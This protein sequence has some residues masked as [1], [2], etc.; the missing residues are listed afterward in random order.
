M[1]RGIDLFHLGLISLPLFNRFLLCGHYR[2]KT[3][4]LWYFKDLQVFLGP[5]SAFKPKSKEA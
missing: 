2:E 5:S 3:T 4:R 1:L